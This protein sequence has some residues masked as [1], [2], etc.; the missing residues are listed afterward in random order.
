MIDHS[1]IFQV[2]RSGAER[3]YQDGIMQQTCEGTGL[4]LCYVLFALRPVPLCTLK[5]ERKGIFENPLVFVTRERAHI[6]QRLV[7]E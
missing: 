3:L 1:N 7:T 2:A 4:L 6:Y 5:Y